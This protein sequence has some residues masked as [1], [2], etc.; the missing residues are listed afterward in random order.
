L[1]VKHVVVSRNYLPEN[2]ITAIDPWSG[3]G[4]DEKLDR[5]AMSMIPVRD[6]AKNTY[7]G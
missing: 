4:S 5:S 3:A 7:L 2:D 1:D 6:E